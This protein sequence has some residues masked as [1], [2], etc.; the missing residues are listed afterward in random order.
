MCR[1]EEKVYVGRDGARQT[2]EDSFPCHNARHG[3]LCSKV[4]RKKIEYIPKHPQISRDDASSPASNNPPTPT[5]SYLVEHRR[6][7]EAARKASVKEGGRAVNHIVID[8]GKKKDKSIKHTAA[9]VKPSKR[10]SVGAAST[11]SSDFAIESPG[12]EASYTL[13]TGFPEGAVPPVQPSGYTTATARAA[14]HH[15]TSSAS[16]VTASSQAPSLYITSDPEPESPLR[17]PARYPRTIVHNPP[18]NA[19]NAFAPPS[20]TTTRAQ[21]QPRAS[22]H[23]SSYRT[24]LA[25]PGSSADDVHPDGLFPLDYSQFQIRSDSSHASSSTR[26]NT[27]SDPAPEITARDVERAHQR[28]LQA[29]ADKKRQVKAD[30]QMAKAL[31]QEEEKR[32]VTFEL[33]RFEARA[34]ERAENQQAHYEQR[35]S[36]L[37]EE[38]RQQQQRK[39]EEENRQQRR[40]E[41]EDREHAAKEAKKAKE[42]AERLEREVKE[43]ERKFREK[44]MERKLKEKEKAERIE[45]EVKEAERKLKAERIEKEKEAERKLKDKEKRDNRP[46][47]RDY[48]KRPTQSSRRTSMTHQDMLEQQR[49]LAQETAQ[50]D[51]ERQAA[52]Q[53]DRDDRAAFLRDQQQQQQYYDPRGGDRRPVTNS[54]PAV[55][56]RSS[57]SGRRG[58]VSMPPPVAVIQNGP[59]GA[60]LTPMNMAF[61]PQYSARAQT[62][63][64]MN[65]PPFARPAPTTRPVPSARHPSYDHDNPFAQPPTR[66]SNTSQDDPFAQS[67]GLVHQGNPFAQQLPTRPA[68][69]PASHDPWVHD[70]REAP[71]RPAGHTRQPSEDRTHTFRGRGEEVLARAAAEKSRPRQHQRT[72]DA[73]HTLPKA[74][75]YEDDY[76]DSDD[77]SVEDRIA[78]YGPRLGLGKPSKK[79]H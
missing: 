18:S 53:R 38:E 72:R 73:S 62:V 48:T 42:K 10:S 37:R 79:K 33:G 63:Q 2:F 44:E 77:E 6:P 66:T 15:A 43:T 68:A 70:P 16:S 56:R 52:E 49:L 27:R 1:V 46:P 30:L 32:Q 28:K 41:E 59:P 40:R 57:V 5:G 60:N 25:T 17:Q 65:A 11:N 12:S 8:F 39:R 64:A 24:V 74:A 9:T 29:E 13:R 19:P 69:P 45:R 31:H 55:G 3:K 58:S 7:S 34:K 22:G 26:S 36:E 61:P 78:G 14:N 35:R 54:G 47:V 67:V 71:A 21:A 23:S 50:M 4:T 20:P 51:R 76:T 75:G